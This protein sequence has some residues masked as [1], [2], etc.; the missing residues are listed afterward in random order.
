LLAASPRIFADAFYNSKDI[1]FLVASIAAILTLVW[2][3][4][5]LRKTRHWG[6]VCALTILHCIASGILISTRVAGIYIL[7]LTIFLLAGG[8]LRSPESLKR[9]LLVLFG[10]LVSTAGLTVLFWP[11]LWHNPWGEFINA[12]SKMSQYPFDRMV[13]YLGKYTPAKSLPWH[14]LPVWIA[15]TMP[16]MVL[17]GLLPGFLG[18]MG[19]VLH[20]VGR[21]K[22][23]KDKNSDQT[24]PGLEDFEWTV[25]LGWLAIP[26]A[27]IF[28]FHSVLYD[29]WRQMFFI[30]PAIVLTSVRGL[31]AV[32]RWL[33]HLNIFTAGIRILAG[34]LLLVG[35]AEPTWFMLRY[36]PYEN[37]YFNA[38]A[39]NPL[40]LRQRF[41]LDYWGLSYK[42]A[43]DFIL[44]HDPSPSIKVFI[45]NPPGLDYI[46]GR[47]NAEQKT[48]LVPVTDPGEA[49]YFVSEFRWHPE[50][51]PYTDVFFSI[52]V[53]GTIIMIVFRLR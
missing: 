19:S 20:T 28:V 8:I 29:G 25:V 34:V 12:F 33:M 22:R 49:N 9:R 42:Q 51:Y 36:H 30:Y 27:A 6:V 47:L 4:D 24:S 1:P 3:S 40:T 13:L 2:L 48:R 26:V 35:L 14:Y 5:S 10:S 31:R 11:I 44:A 41:E 23:G 39:G 21:I 53:R 50:D 15:I 45:A 43:I 46:N 37:V 18:W 38:L 52:N 32:Y 7:P 17:A 16:M